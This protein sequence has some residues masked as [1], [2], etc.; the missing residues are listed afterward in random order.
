[1]S[2]QIEVSQGSW[3]PRQELQKAGGNSQAN[4]VCI[5]HVHKSALTSSADCHKSLVSLTRAVRTSPGPLPSHLACSPDQPDRQ[6]FVFP[7]RSPHQE[8]LKPRSPRDLTRRPACLCSATVLQLYLAAR[9]S[10]TAGT[11]FWA[12]RDRANLP[13]R[14][15]YACWRLLSIYH[16]AMARISWL[17]DKH[18]GGHQGSNRTQGAIDIRIETERLKR[19]IAPGESLEA[20][21]SAR[22]HMNCLPAV[23]RH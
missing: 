8:R 21:R 7:R 15:G 16:E 22:R 4:E 19:R 2:A 20:F 11:S 3:P 1:M 10:A 23:L 13:S 6:P 14:H 18:L 5:H 17:A 9:V 12:P